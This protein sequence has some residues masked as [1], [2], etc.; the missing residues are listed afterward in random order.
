MDLTE[1]I[2]AMLLTMTQKQVSELTGIH[3]TTI[4]QINNGKP[5]NDMQAEVIAKKCGVIF[6]GNRCTYSEVTERITQYYDELP[7][8]QKTKFKQIS[9]VSQNDILQIRKHKRVKWCK[10]V[11]MSKYF[12]YTLALNLPEVKRK[13]VKN[14][15]TG[16]AEPY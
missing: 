1:H 16:W 12:G 3:Q 15:F 10:L 14:G 8:L 2:R 4:S 5:A 7:K 9:D 13:G 6:G 11:S